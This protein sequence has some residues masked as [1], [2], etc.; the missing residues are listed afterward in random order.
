MKKRCLRIRREHIN[1]FLAF[2]IPYPVLVAH[3]LCSIRHRNHSLGTECPV[4]DDWEW[5]IASKCRSVIDALQ[6][7]TL[8]TCVLRI[9]AQA[10]SHLQKRDGLAV[11]I[12]ACFGR[13]GGGDR[14]GVFAVGVPGEGVVVGMQC[15]GCHASFSIW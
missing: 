11:Q 15:Y 6:A 12:L 5:V 8:L 3:Q 7:M 10:G 9:R 1:V 13:N 2:W 4:K 14:R